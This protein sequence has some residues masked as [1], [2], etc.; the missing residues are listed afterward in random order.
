MTSM[1]HVAFVLVFGHLSFC[2]VLFF[3]LTVAQQTKQQENKS[4]YFFTGSCRFRYDG[5]GSGNGNGIG[6]N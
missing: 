1:W 4:K 6:I 2:F 5:K 3:H